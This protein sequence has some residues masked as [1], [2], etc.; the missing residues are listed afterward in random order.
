MSIRAV[1]TEMVMRITSFEGLARN[2]DETI[3][4][5][6]EVIAKLPTT[7]SGMNEIGSRPH[8]KQSKNSS[9][10]AEPIT[11]MKPH[12]RKPALLQVEVPM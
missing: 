2:T 8:T 12:I 11:A 4:P 5:K 1:H 10:P 9:I 7:F 6:I 3:R